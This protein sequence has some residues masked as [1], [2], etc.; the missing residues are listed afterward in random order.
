MRIE[1]A[2]GDSQSA[3]DM[4]LSVSPALSSMVAERPAS[5]KLPSSDLIACSG[6]KARVVIRVANP[7]KIKSPR[8]AAT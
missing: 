7:L 2:R 6:S 8:I 4:I 1:E 3:G 5:S